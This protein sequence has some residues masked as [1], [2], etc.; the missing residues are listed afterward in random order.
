M[1]TVVLDTN[2]LIDNVHGFA[3]WV[4]N[5]LKQP[6]EYRLV[7]P[8]IA[9]AEYLTA[10]ETETVTGRE[11]SKDYL[12]LFE[13]LDLTFEIA[14]VLGK[15]LRRKTYPASANTADLIIASTAIYLDGELATQNKSDFENI[16]RLRLFGPEK[17]KN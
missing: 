3:P 4:N 8:T 7:V 6:Q 10:E 14:E 12:A 13:I 15:I 2:I 5:L 9:V 16:P 1:K 17:L 11:K